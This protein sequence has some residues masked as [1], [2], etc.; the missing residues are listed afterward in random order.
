MTKEQF[1]KAK[2]IENEMIELE[3]DITGYECIPMVHG[4]LIYR[5]G[6]VMI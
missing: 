2:S 6:C 5:Y 1:D 4:T 3:L